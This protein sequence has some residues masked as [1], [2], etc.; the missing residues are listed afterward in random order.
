MTSNKICM[1]RHVLTVDGLG[2]ESLEGICWLVGC[3][4][5]GY[6]CAMAI[7]AGRLF[8]D[9]RLV[10]KVIWGWYLKLVLL[11]DFACRI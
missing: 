3:F 5:G 8:E 7:Y 11:V 6:V 1:T 10:D 9:L 4:D 2:R